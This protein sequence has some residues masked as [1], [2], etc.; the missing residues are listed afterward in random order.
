MVAFLFIYSHIILLP[1][2]S[3][4]VLLLLVQC[5][6]GLDQMRKT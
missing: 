2:Y 3:H 1:I 5:F 4:I 6:D